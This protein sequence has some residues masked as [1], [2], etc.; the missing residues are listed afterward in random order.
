MSKRPITASYIFF[1]L[2]LSDDTWRIAAGFIAAVWLGPTVTQGREMSQ[3]AAALVW[4]MIMAIGWSLSAW[5]ARKI[6]DALKRA[7]KR[8]SK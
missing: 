8:A 1:Y 2:L 4:L 7:V 5:P 6:T 3:G